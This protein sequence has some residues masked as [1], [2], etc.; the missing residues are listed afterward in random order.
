M[1]RNDAPKHHP[2]TVAPSSLVQSRP[3]TLAQSMD[4]RADCVEIGEMS[5]PSEGTWK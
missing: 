2:D 4:K 5:E 3:S 1:Y